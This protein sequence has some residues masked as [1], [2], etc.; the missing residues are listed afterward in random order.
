MLI[1]VITTRERSYAIVTVIP[2]ELFVYSP[3]VAGQT[4]LRMFSRE[5]LTTINDLACE[6]PVTNRR[7]KTYRRVR[8]A[9]CAT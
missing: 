7:A 4:S 6:Y 1:T 2:V 5:G 8:R 9:C 3:S